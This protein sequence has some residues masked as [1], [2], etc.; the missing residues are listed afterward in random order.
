MTL[1]QT[2]WSA[3]SQLQGQDL[4]DQ[5]FS[6]FQRISRDIQLRER[7]DPS[8][9]SAVPRLAALLEARPELERYEELLSALARSV[10]LWNYIDKSHADARDRLVAEAV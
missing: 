2:E 7:D 8:V 5:V 3:L 4:F 6:V 1:S 9:L 10:G